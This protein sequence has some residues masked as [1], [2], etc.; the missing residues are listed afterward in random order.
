MDVVG[1]GLYG[2]LIFCGIRWKSLGEDIAFESGDV[3]FETWFLR[4]VGIPISIPGSAPAGTGNSLLFHLG[5]VTYGDV[6]HLN[7]FLNNVETTYVL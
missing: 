5:F 3:T 2:V 6:I 7:A 4:G 1:E